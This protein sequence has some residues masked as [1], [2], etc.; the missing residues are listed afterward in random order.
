MRRSFSSLATAG[1]CT[2]YLVR[3]RG[4]TAADDEWLRLEELA[5][6]PKKVAE[7]DAAAPRPRA[8]RR[9]FACAAPYLPRARPFKLAPFTATAGSRLAAP[10][11]LA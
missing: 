3:L 4:Y 10:S 11:K 7:Y 8:A 5:H 6:C 1:W 9:G 2:A